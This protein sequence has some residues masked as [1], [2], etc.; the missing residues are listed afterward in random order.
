MYIRIDKKKKGGGHKNKNSD[1]VSGIKKKCR[2][3]VLSSHTLILCV[4]WWDV[5]VS[6]NA[7]ETVV[8][9]SNIC[10]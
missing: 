6:E 10:H 4:N 9:I 8:T 3:L 7:N 5:T 1:D 2:S